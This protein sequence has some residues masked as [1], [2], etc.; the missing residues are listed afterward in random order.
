MSRKCQDQY[1]NPACYIELPATLPDGSGEYKVK[2]STELID[3]MQ[4]HDRKLFFELQHSTVRSILLNPEFVFQGIREYESG[5]HAY[6]ARPAYAMTNDGVRVQPWQGCVF[7]VFVNRNGCVYNWMWDD[8]DPGR[9]G[10][11]INHKTRFERMLWT[12]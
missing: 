4:K 1:N 11:P 3:D 12:R 5:G 6:V 7:L 10:M 8:E 9:E 2:I